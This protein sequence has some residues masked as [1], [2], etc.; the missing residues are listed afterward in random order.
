MK[1]FIEEI[2]QDE[3]PQSQEA[4]FTLKIIKDQRGMIACLQLIQDDLVRGDVMEG[5][6]LVKDLKP[7]I[8]GIAQTVM[9][10]YERMSKTDLNKL[11]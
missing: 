4:V 1:T 10:Q 8:D 6:R 7:Y 2:S 5:D 9:K 11:S 3:M